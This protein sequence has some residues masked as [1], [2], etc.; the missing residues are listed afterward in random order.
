LKIMS[1]PCEFQI[2]P[3]GLS[4]WQLCNLRGARAIMLA[5]AGLGAAEYAIMPVAPSYY[6]QGP[7][8]RTRAPTSRSSRWRRSSPTC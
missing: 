5:T 7:V 1:Q 6:Q 4:A 3:G 8:R 2:P